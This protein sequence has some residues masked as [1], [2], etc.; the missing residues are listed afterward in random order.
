MKKF[1][2]GF[3]ILGVLASVFA[4]PATSPAGNLNY[5]QEKVTGMGSSVNYD[6]LVG[7]DSC[8]L[9]NKKT[10]PVGCALILNRSA[11]AGTGLDS[12]ALQV[13]IDSYSSSGIFM[14]R[15]VVDTIVTASSTTAGEQM[16]LPIG[17]TVFGDL[18]TIKLKYYGTTLNG[19]QVI[20]TPWSIYSRKTFTFTRQII[21]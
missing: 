15:N 13:I 16:L 4:A 21:F 3:I 10:F 20:I 18:F 17:I 1:L 11:I 14:N 9:V 5:F 6:T 19:G 8:T 7:D 2:F 12:V